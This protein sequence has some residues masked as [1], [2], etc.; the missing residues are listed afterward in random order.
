ML[1][2]GTKFTNRFT[3]SPAVYEGFI[4][5]FMD[6]N[7]LHTSSVFA[8]EKGFKSNVMH[9][10]ILNGFLSYFIGE[11]LPTKNVIIHSQDIKFSKPV[12]LKDTVVLQAQVKDYFES[13]N[14]VHISFYFE[15]EQQ[16]KVASG[17]VHIGILK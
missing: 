7:P 4:N 16:I 8:I 14:V 5:I 9:G 15:N 1:S 10:N 3:V 2:K 17:N 13:V 12:Y 11:C 6:R